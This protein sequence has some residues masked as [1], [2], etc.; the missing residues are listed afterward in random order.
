MTDTPVVQVQ[1]LKEDR[2]RE[3]RRMIANL[4]RSRTM[5]LKRYPSDATAKAT[6]AKQEDKLVR[7]LEAL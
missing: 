3:L 1:Q 5:Y 4:R 2:K 6:Y 7:E